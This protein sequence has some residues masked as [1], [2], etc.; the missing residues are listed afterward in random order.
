MKK[1]QGSE[2]E[3][4]E[5]ELSIHSMAKNISCENSKKGGKMVPRQSWN[6]KKKNHKKI[7]QFERK[8]QI[9]Y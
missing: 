5:N 4:N 3:L 1:K 6:L 9:S 8:M 2:K 7:Q